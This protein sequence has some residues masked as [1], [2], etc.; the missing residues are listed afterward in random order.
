MWSD[1][2]DDKFGLKNGTADNILNSSK[3]KTFQDL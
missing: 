2:S 1:H 3:T